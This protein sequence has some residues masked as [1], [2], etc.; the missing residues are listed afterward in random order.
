MNIEQLLVFGDH[1]SLLQ[2]YPTVFCTCA[3]TE[4]RALMVSRMLYTSLHYIISPL[5]VLYK[6]HS[7][8]RVLEER[9]NVETH[10]LVSFQKPWN[11][12]SLKKFVHDLP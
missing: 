3:Q 6:K 8:I 9:E 1:Y 2:S 5:S 12:T 7:H 4:K 11:E 10:S